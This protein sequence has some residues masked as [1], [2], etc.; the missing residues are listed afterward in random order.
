MSQFH[1]YADYYDTLYKEKDYAAECDF[2]E[3]MMRQY[4]NLSV[5]T[6][7][8]LGCGTGGHAL[9]LARRGYLVTGV[10]ISSKMVQRARSKA[11]RDNLPLTL[12]MGDVRHLDL[13]S[14]FDAA[15]CMFA[16]M[17]YLTTN[18]DIQQACDSVRKH[19]HPGGIFVFD[20]WNGLAV[21]RA[22]PSVRV[23]EIKD[24]GLNLIRIAQPRLDAYH[25]LC[26]VEYHVLVTRDGQVAD[27]IKETHRLRFLFPQEIAHYLE[28]A[29]FELL[30]ICPFLNAEGR[31][32]ENEW[33]IMAIARAA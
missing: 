11:E 22:L 4:S 19:L 5:K 16:V 12:Q 2:V 13:Q 33:N 7:L 14:Q 10:D 32:D 26:E 28:E 30:K 27:E 15:I 21:L 23:K 18:A 9:A 6:I 8:D 29:G 20:F 31:V 17:N 3:Q 1:D 24:G 25:H